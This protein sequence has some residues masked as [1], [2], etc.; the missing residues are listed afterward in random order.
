MSR[1]SKSKGIEPSIAWR[2]FG[3]A[4]R[5]ILLSATRRKRTRFWNAETASRCAH[6]PLHP[7]DSQ[8]NKMHIVEVYTRPRILFLQ[9]TCIL[10]VPAYTLYICWLYRT[11]YRVPSHALGMQIKIHD[12]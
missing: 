8:Q 11:T 7:I 3:Y 10:Y 5:L 2:D 9:N 4:H 1:D 6:V 12:S